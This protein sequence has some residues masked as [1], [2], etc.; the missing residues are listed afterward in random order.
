MGGGGGVRGSR[1]RLE[2]VQ[3]NAVFCFRDSPNFK[4][5]KCK[6]IPKVNNYSLKSR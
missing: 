6:N 2:G 1:D 4:T 5:P 3:Q